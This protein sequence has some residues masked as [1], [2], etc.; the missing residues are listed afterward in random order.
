MRHI[1]LA[2][3]MIRS[4]AG[5]VY[6]MFCSFLAAPFY[7]WWFKFDEQLRNKAYYFVFWV[8]LAI[9]AAFFVLRLLRIANEQTY[10]TVSIAIYASALV[11]AELFIGHRLCVFLCGAVGGGIILVAFLL[12]V[13]TT[14]G[15]LW[16]VGEMKSSS[17]ESKLL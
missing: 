4:I 3:Q 14:Y 8:G 5:L 10:Y 15:Y 13:L 2:N 9:A 16:I 7:G 12:A 1:E 11:A 6:L 17:S